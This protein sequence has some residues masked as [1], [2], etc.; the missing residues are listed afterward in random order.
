MPNPKSGPQK[1][2]NTKKDKK[3]DDFSWPGTDRVVGKAQHI[4]GA[5][6]NILEEEIAAGIL[7]AKNIEKKLIDVNKVRSDPNE[8]MGRIRRD[9]HEL[10]D[11]FLDAFTSMTQQ[12]NAVVDAVKKENGQSATPE[13]PDEPK[14]KPAAD[15]LVLKPE[16]PVKPGKMVSMTLSLQD[17]GT[18][19]PG[20]IVFRKTDLIGPGH[21]KIGLRA[22][23]I[24]PGTLL[25]KANEQKDVSITVK[26]PRKAKAGRYNA[27]LSDINNRELCILVAIEVIE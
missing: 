8:L 2:H 11:L 12:M 22:I 20:T 18:E 5:A 10:L 13:K 25:L 1:N 23:T 15:V 7:A 21:E 19:K 27:F 26:V 24:T 17:D 16:Q 9:S 3:T 14:T 6:V 4:I